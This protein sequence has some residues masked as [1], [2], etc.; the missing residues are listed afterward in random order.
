MESWKVVP[1]AGGVMIRRLGSKLCHMMDMLKVFCVCALFLP[2]IALSQR[3]VTGRVVDQSQNPIP[4]ATLRVVGNTEKKA[5]ANV[6]GFFSIEL[7]SG[8]TSL[9]ADCIGFEPA[10]FEVPE[11]ERVMVT[12][13]TIYIRL[14]T[15]LLVQ[16]VLRSSR[17]DSLDIL[18]PEF[19]KFPGGLNDF[20]AQLTAGLIRN[21]VDSLIK[22]PTTLNF[23]VDKS[24]T[25]QT[26]P[27][28]NAA[29]DSAIKNVIEKLPK[30][31]P[32]NQNGFPTVQYFATTL[33][34]EQIF[35]VVEVSA[36]PKGGMAE[37]YKFV[38]TNIRYPK[39]ARKIG[40]EGRLFVTFIVEKDGSL[41]EIK[42]VEDRG[43]GGGCDEEAVRV[44][45]LSPKWIPGTQKGKP[46]RQRY[47]VPINFRLR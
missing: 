44:V 17:M 28:G 39:Y 19:A 38:E 26:F 13:K 41:T 33:A 22:E 47:T 12:L 43:I 7:G 2:N 4:Y 32:A 1:T 6:K 25:L 15:V 35:R 21:K 37:F 30:W 8:E 42:V 14:D 23:A 10:F 40:L 3:V 9:E 29:I 11:S 20:T 46:V 45:S 34:P 36:Y 16:P 31:Q 18:F 27:I 24:G 5:I